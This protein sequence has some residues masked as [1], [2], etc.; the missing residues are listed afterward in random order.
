MKKLSII[1]L[2]AILI[3]AFASIS[4]AGPIVGTIEEVSS[5]KDGVSIRIKRSPDGASIPGIVDPDIANHV[6]AIALTAKVDGKQVRAV[7][8]GPDAQHPSQWWKDI[9]ILE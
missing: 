5:G 6:L 7:L 4:Q 2:V 9:R 1:G 8:K 3:L